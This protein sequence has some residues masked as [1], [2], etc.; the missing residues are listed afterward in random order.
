MSEEAI[1]IDS[2]LE[3]LGELVDKTGDLSDIEERLDEIQS[4]MGKIEERTDAIEGYTE[5][6][7]QTMDHPAL[8]TPF[9]DYT[10]TEAFLLLLLLYLFL[11]SCA[12]MLRG[13]FSWLRS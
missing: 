2:I 1:V 11:S 9:E 8:T 4:D 5:T 7:V 12:R 3:L 13:G 6:I 10:V